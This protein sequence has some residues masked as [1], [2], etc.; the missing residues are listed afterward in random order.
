MWPDCKV[1]GGK[2]E[3][4]GH[5][6]AGRSC[7]VRNG[8]Y[9]PLTGMPVPYFRC[10]KCGFLFTDHCDDWSTEDFRRWI[11]NADYHKADPGWVDGMRAELSAELTRDVMVQLGATSTLDYGCHEGV[12]T[13]ALRAKGWDA[14]GYEPL[15]CKPLPCRRFDLVTAFEV[16]EHTP[17][18]RKTMGEMIS[19]TRPGGHVLL[20]TCTIDDLKPQE[21][22][23]W[24]IAP[25]NG[26]ISIFTST[27][28]ANLFDV[29]DWKVAVVG[30]NT[31]LGMAR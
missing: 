21:T 26:H 31:F 30:P 25:R 9:L 11:Y 2:T 10:Q 5:V 17:D 12:L 1:C 3:V 13:R 28:L 4:H 16:I 15:G 6:D 24:Y 18:P 23:F 7:E 8:T 19:V 14:D 29:F 27:S 22:D 20:T